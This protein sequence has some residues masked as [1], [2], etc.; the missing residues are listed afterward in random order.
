MH[1]RYSAVVASR[2]SGSQPAAILW[3]YVLPYFRIYVLLYI[4]IIHVSFLLYT[5]EIHL[6][7]FPWSC[8]AKGLLSAFFSFLLDLT[9][10]TG[11]WVFPL[12]K[13]GYP[14]TFPGLCVYAYMSYLVL[15]VHIFYVFSGTAFEP[16]IFS[17]FSVAEM[18]PQ[19]R[20]PSEN[21]KQPIGQRWLV[22][23]LMSLDPSLTAV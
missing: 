8:H 23:A 22:S 13:S 10:Q 11:V 4:H 6:Y 20:A 12:P 19:G 2:L 9:W 7:S 16:S 17:L 5:S 21:R 3:M 1:N 18:P 15:Q 14:M